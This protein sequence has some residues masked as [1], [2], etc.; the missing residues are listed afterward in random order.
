MVVTVVKRDCRSCTIVKVEVCDT[1]W[2]GLIGLVGSWW[3]SCVTSSWRNSLEFS[4]PS[5]CPADEAC[6]DEVALFGFVAAV[7]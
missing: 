4:D 7:A 6:D 5:A 1:I 3:V 2:V